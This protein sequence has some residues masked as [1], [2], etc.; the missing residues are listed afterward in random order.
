MGDVTDL[1]LV[2][3]HR[4]ALADIAGV[5]LGAA[6]VA[7]AEA[8]QVQ[9]GVHPGHL[10]DHRVQNHPAPLV[11]QE[12]GRKVLEGLAQRRRLA[13]RRFRPRDLE[14]DARGQQDQDDQGRNRHPAPWRRARP[15]ELVLLVRPAH[16]IQPPS[17][18]AT[19]AAESS[20][21]GGTAVA[22]SRSFFMASRNRISTHSRKKARGNMAKPA[23][24]CCMP[25]IAMSL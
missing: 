20:F 3:D 16:F 25:F 22:Q 4:R 24:S 14:A 18:P 8:R 5:D 2:L 17:P 19:S 15:V 23:I 7:P 13:A 9:V 12:I 21:A 11:A 10:L 1:R 6:A